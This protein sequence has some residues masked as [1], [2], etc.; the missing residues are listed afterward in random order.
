MDIYKKYNYQFNLPASVPFNSLVNL[1]HLVFEVTTHCNL[2]C[3]Y[4][5]YG[6]LYNMRTHQERIHMPFEMAKLL[7]DYL[8]NIWDKYKIDYDVRDTFVGFYGG[9]PLLNFKLI[10]EIVE[11]VENHPLHNRHFYYT[12]TTNAMLLDKYMDFLAEKN[13]YLVISLDGDEMAHSYRVDCTGKNSFKEVF[14]KVRKLQVR[15]PEYFEKKVSFNSVLTNRGRLLD[16]KKFILD[17][18][19]KNPMVSEV[20]DFG[21]LK[22]KKD[23]F[24]KIFRSIKQETN[25]DLCKKYLNDVDFPKIPEN[26]ISYTILRYLSGNSFPSY[27]SLLPQKEGKIFPTGTCF[28]FDKK[29]FVNV[30]G[31][32]LPCERINQKYSL[33]VIKEDGVH[34]DFDSIAKKYSE[35][36]K[37]VYDL[38]KACY[39][40]PICEQ[41]MFYIS[42]LE[43][44]PSC[45]NFLNKRQYEELITRHL[46]YLSDNPAIYQRIMK[47]MY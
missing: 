22:D 31:E 14:N 16:V 13:F 34:I 24:D 42:K 18:F 44:K 2:N 33:G 29:M 39:A 17:N 47:E 8:Y 7:M 23:E 46:K 19:G 41:C 12:M 11:Y 15:Y 28:P 26:R 45:S 36:Y 1:R 9:E 38:C 20:N 30:K 43:E 3:T 6:A 5:G 37:R 10:K 40:K 32:L 25:N 35:Y 27:N 4:C 21:V